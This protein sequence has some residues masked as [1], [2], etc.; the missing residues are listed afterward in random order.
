MVMHDELERIEGKAGMAD[1]RVERLS[2]TK[3]D[4]ISGTLAE[5]PYLRASAEACWL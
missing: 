3:N 2:K 5:V 4:A 1:F